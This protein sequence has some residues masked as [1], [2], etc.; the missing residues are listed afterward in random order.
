MNVLFISQCQKRALTQTRR[1]LDQFAERRGDCA[2]QTAITQAGLDTVRRMLRKTAR[3]N[4][5]VACH[6][7]RGKDHSELMW[8]VGDASRFNP[9]GAVPTNT[10][11]NDV[12]RRADENDW[13]T[14]QVIGLLAQLAALL[15]DLGKATIAFQQ[16][17]T[18]RLQ[19]R[20]LYRH[21]WVSL[22]MFQAFVGGDD[23]ISWLQRLADP[24]LCDESQ[25]LATDRYQR[26]GVD[27]A[28]NR[29][30]F[31]QL[32]PLAATVGWLVVTHH[33][34]PL[35]PCDDGNDGQGWLGKRVKRF[36][37]AWVESPL[38]QVAHDWNE[39]RQT[40]DLAHIKPYWQPAGPLPTV[41]A[42][43]RA[44]AAGWPSSCS[45]SASAKP[46]KTGW[47]TLM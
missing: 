2:W 4:T 19:E 31:R 8:V 47:A 7:I 26:D 38:T 32:P 25:W 27:A 44:K 43:W 11:S 24:E 34:L 17:L 33:R 46:V 15:H 10:T 39:I 40:T 30:P 22:R 18:G 14:L 36:N 16:R 35:V 37:L 9:Q 5:A 23:D 42:K 3:R 12:L 41:E 29:F 13:H 28:I 45:K 1:I 21:E 20:N 6:W